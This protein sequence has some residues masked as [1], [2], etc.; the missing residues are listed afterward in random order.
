MLIAEAI[1]GVVMPAPPF[2]YRLIKRVPAVESVKPP[3]IKQRSKA[4]NKI[5]DDEDWLRDL[6]IERPAPEPNLAIEGHDVTVR[7]GAQGSP[8]LVLDFNSYRYAP[9]GPERD[10]AFVEQDITWVV[11][12]EGVLYVSHGH[13]TYAE[14]SGGLNAYIT[15]IDLGTREVLWRSAPLVSNS[16]N[17]LIRGAH[18]ITGYGFT[19]EP[20]FLYIL[21]LATGQTLRKRKLATGPDYFVEK[22]GLLHVRCYNTD[23]VFEL[24]D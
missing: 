9:A 3:Q 23:Y 22:D 8:D 7:G 4:R 18:I 11:L 24:K 2:E 20:D 12:R 14:S 16:R 6:G 13:R 5:I 17:F 15:A 10:R 19:D 21:D 1:Q